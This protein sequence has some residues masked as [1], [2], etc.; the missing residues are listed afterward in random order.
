M[1][2]LLELDIYIYVLL[3]IPVNIIKRVVF[4]VG[5]PPSHI[6]YYLYV[7]FDYRRG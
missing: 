5:V 6:I 3:Y 4:F 2:V 7:L 1:G